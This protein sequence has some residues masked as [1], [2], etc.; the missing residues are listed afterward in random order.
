M[1]VDMLRK[2]GKPVDAIVAC[3]AFLK[4][5]PNE[6]W[7]TVAAVYLV[8][9]IAFKEYTE[10]PARQQLFQRIVDGFA[11]CPSYYVMAACEL[12]ISYMWWPSGRDLPKAEQVMAKALDQT[13]GKIPV[14]FSS[15][16]AMV[17]HL[18]NA[19]R[20]QNKLDE[21]EAGLKEAVALNPRVLTVPD[22][23]FFG[24]E[25][26]KQKTDPDAMLAAAKLGYVLCDYTTED[27]K[28]SIDRVT[29]A[30]GAT[31]GPGL[32]LAFAR[33]QD[34][35][36]L[37]NPLRDVKLPDWG[38]PDKLLAAAGD[39]GAGKFNVLLYAGRLA[40]AVK[41]GKQ[42]ML[43]AAGGDQNALATA[44]RNLAR[45]FKA[46]DLSLVRANA[47]LEYHRTGQGKNLLPDLEAELKA[48]ADAAGAK[49]AAEA[50][51][52]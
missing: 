23:A 36:K 50:G 34:D 20:M 8:R 18:A 39:D 45:C 25:I 21:A 48:A 43:G 32:G 3:E 16:P 28:R 49:P 1:A 7:Q 6:G 47:F 38:D 27:L 41:L 51:R 33:C 17:V 5:H 19:R 26:A 30:L 12:G 40:E 9:E 4:A 37:D 14:W 24:I 10:L 13:K 31:G 22:F 42:Q 15:W 2:A 46:K 11:D 35:P 52:P 44:M 29:A